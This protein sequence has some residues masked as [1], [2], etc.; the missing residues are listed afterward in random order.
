MAL[1]ASLPPSPGA[2][3]L[4]LAALVLVALA[5]AA[6]FGLA[7]AFLPWWLV[8]ALVLLPL[9]VLGGAAWPYPVLLFALALVF[10]AIP[11][12]FVPPVGSFRVHELIIMYLALVVVLRALWTREPLLA[13]SRPFLWALL[14]LA[15][16]V[17]ASAVY[18]RFFARNQFLITELRG[19]VMWLV[20]PL[21]AFC[22]R[23]PGQRQALVAFLVGTGVV[24]GAYT[25]A[26]SV[27]GVWLLNDR[28]EA[29]DVT[30]L[31]VT[32]SLAGATTYLM[33]FTVFWAVN[34][35]TVR[36]RGWWLALALALVAGGGIAV[37]FGRG[38]WLAMAAGFLVATFL[39]R[40]L[41]GML[42]SALVGAL[43]VLLVLLTLS[44]AQPRLAEAVVE[45]ATGTGLELRSGGSF[46]WRLTEIHEAMKAIA[47]RPFTGVGIGGDYKQHVS[48]IGGFRN[49]TRYIH[50]AYVGYMVKMGVHALLFQIAF[51]ALFAGLAWRLRREVAEAD[52]PA[53]AALVGAFCVPVITS[54]TQP[55]WFTNPG[56]AAFCAFAAL[57][58]KYRPQPT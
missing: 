2:Q 53:Y 40:G 23:T 1:A 8:V 21:L 41:R 10:Q 34:R 45:R 36:A 54:F 12:R 48:A 27:L 37:S 49:E 44:V 31:D 15:A 35:A 26:Q 4:R 11:G 13:P 24:V 7:I 50:N 14:Y 32:R 18:A 33:V 39:N 43:A 22:I 6:F 25:V 46:R 16:C 28:V 30:N 5:A 29:L 58:L 56:V 19:F 51:V 17:V 55:E 38:V 57:L 47:E 52:R 20:L 3:A 42:V 9:V